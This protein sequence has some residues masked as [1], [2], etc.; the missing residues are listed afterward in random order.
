[1]VFQ[2]DHL[3]QIEDHMV[4]IV[5]ESKMEVRDRLDQLQDLTLMLMMF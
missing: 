2:M 3:D 5:L 4:V 1:M